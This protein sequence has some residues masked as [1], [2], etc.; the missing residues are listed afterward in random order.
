MVN[1]EAT[2]TNMIW[3]F[4]ADWETAGNH[5]VNEKISHTILCIQISIYKYKYERKHSVV[6]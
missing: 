4:W 3:F 2:I 1:K 5:I 6:R